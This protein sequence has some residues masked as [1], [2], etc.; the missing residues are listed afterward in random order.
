MMEMGAYEY[1]WT[2]PGQTF[3][4][5][6][7]KF[8]IGDRLPSD[9]VD[10]PVAEEYAHKTTEILR[11]GAVDRFGLRIKGTGD[12]PERLQE[13]HPLELL[14]FQGCW[15]L[16]ETKCI[17]VVG[18][19]NPTPDG[20][21]RTRKI[22]RALVK[23]GFTIVSGLAAGIDRAA[24]TTA[25]E[26]GGL[27]IGVIGTPLSQSYPRENVE[28][29]RRIAT[30]YLLISQVPVIRHS[31][32]DWR[33][34]RAFFPQRNITMSALTSGTVIV[35]ASD[36][37]GTLMQAKAA[38][39]QGRKLFILDSCFQ[40]SSLEWPRKYEAEGAIRVRTYADIQAHL[41]EPPQN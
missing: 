40:N 5:L 33:Q 2:M 14:Y 23:D 13:A 10:A 32:Q 30:E 25:I 34:N 9:F 8:K 31:Q 3:N 18:T 15:E 36:T 37:S 35:E 24:H 27:T 19:R 28:L 38:L 11:D 4:R 16:I 7:D 1:L 12:Y 39:K 22:V 29:Q 6:A 26:E 21:A 20:L 41:V 17:A